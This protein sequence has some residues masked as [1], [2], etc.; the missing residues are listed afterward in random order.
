MTP[1]FL[2]RTCNR[3]RLGDRRRWSIFDGC[4]DRRAVYQGGLPAAAFVS[5]RPVA[6]A[7]HQKQQYAGYAQETSSVDDGG[8]NGDSGSRTRRSTAQTQGVFSLVAKKH[9]YLLHVPKQLLYMALQSRVVQSP[10]AFNVQTKMVGNRSWYNASFTDPFEETFDSGLGKE[11]GVPPNKSASMRTPLHQ[12]EV[13]VIDGLV[14]YDSPR[15]AEHAAA[16]ES[17][18]SS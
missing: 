2:R 8:G 15:R 1:V 17:V 4:R 3:L 11:L 5:H 6:S 18:P 14:Y 7:A 9:P 10:L 13:Q 16:G 12:A